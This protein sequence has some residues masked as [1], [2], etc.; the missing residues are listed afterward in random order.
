MGKE[1]IPSKYYGFYEELAQIVGDKHIKEI[2]NQFKGLEIS[3][4]RR[5]FSSDYVINLALTNTERSLRDLAREYGYNE[6]YLKRLVS[7]RKREIS[8]P[9]DSKDSLLI[10]H[11]P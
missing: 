11:A 10:K 3:F 6:K 7:Q 9:T 2:Y 1:S 5:L 8:E 4:P